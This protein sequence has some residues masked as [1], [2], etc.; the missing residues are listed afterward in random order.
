MVEEVAAVKE[1]E[2]S[3]MVPLLDR[4]FLE[5]AP[6]GKL[7]SEADIICIIY[8]FTSSQFIGFQGKNLIFPP[9]SPHLGLNKIPFSGVPSL[10]GPPGEIPELRGPL[11]KY[12]SSVGPLVKYLSSMG[13]LVKYLSS[14]GL[15]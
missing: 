12:L 4:P 3:D 1:Q 11:V 14:V 5:E 9:H 7:P 8:H 6:A 15:W 2:A 13:P 10:R